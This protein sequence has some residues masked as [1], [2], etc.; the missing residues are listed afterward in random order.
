MN[1]L[2]QINRTNMDCAIQ[3]FEEL[4]ASMQE[5]TAAILREQREQ[6]T[7]ANSSISFVRGNNQRV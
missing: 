5:H 4:T 6:Q 3:A 7:A 1:R 2:E